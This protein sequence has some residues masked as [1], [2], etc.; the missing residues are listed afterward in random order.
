MTQEALAA[1]LGIEPGTL[2]RYEQGRVPLTVPLLVLA[3]KAL[4]VQPAQLLAGVAQDA[5]AGDEES[6]M[7]RL[8]HAMPPARRAALIG[9]LREMRD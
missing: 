2:S 1:T 7:L 8:W 3:A 6:E 5:P 4:G 9:L